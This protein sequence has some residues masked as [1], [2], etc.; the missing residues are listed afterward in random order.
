[1]IQFYIQ[2]FT[3]YVSQTIH[4]IQNTSH[5]F[6]ISRSQR[7]VAAHHPYPR[8]E[9]EEQ[10]GAHWRGRAWK[11]WPFSFKWQVWYEK[12]RCPIIAAFSNLSFPWFWKFQSL[13]FTDLPKMFFVPRLELAR[14][15]L[16]WVL[17]NSLLRARYLWTYR[18]GTIPKMAKF[19]GR[20]WRNNTGKDLC[21]KNPNEIFV[22]KPF[23]NFLMKW[24]EFMQESYLSYLS[25]LSNSLQRT[26]K[27]QAQCNSSCAVLCLIN[28]RESYRGIVV[29]LRSFSWTW[30]FFWP[31]RAIGVTLRISRSFP[32]VN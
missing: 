9:D 5:H 1:M 22:P 11:S 3:F 27:F 4:R 32:E 24:V 6:C 18:C 29:S 26:R 19:C 28:L 17:H 25:Y 20:W 30:L 21:F 7:W 31:A 23:G 2:H 12:N 13:K 8:E 16:H 14:P 15:P 10:P